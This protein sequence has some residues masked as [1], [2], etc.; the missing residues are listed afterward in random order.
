VGAAGGGGGIRG[1]GSGGGGN[2]GAGS[3]GIERVAGV[4]GEDGGD[5]RDG[6]GIGVRGIAMESRGVGM[7]GVWGDW[8]G[9]VEAG[10]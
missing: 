5:V 4:H 1:G 9:G 2:C 3:G 6:A 10:A 7:G 8:I